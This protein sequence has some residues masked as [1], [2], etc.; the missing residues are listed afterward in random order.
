MLSRIRSRW[1]CGVSNLQ[2]LHSLVHVPHSCL[3]PLPRLVQALHC[4]LRSL[5]CTVKSLPSVSRQLSE[6]LWHLH[7]KKPGVMW[8][9]G[10]QVRPQLGAALPANALYEEP[11]HQEEV[12]LYFGIID[13]L[14]V[15][16]TCCHMSVCF[17]FWGTHAWA[18]HQ[19]DICPSR[20]HLC[21][22]S[23]LVDAHACCQP[24][25]T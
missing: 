25:A 10:V 18:L 21:S 23:L 2:R 11:A 13:F 4:L 14:Q 3:C 22:D 12:L 16:E 8:Q 17:N 6:H 19:A 1:P 15:G 7:W 5:M 9:S 24:T 20:R